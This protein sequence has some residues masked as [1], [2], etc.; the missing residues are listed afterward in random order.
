VLREETL[1]FGAKDCQRAMAENKQRC[2]KC[3]TLDTSGFFDKGFIP[4]PDDKIACDTCGEW[5]AWQL[6]RCAECP[7]NKLVK[8]RMTHEHW[9]LLMR[10]VEL[11]KNTNVFAVDW[12]DI[13]SIDAE[14]LQIWRHERARH[15]AEQFKKQQEQLNGR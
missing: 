9:P 13:D 12:G 5:R 10:V 11:E 14:A 15:E 8:L 6:E 1:C 7:R 2:M 3:K 4:G